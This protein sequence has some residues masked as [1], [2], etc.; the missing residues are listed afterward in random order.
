[1]S[2]ILQDI[3]VRLGGREVVSGLTLPPLPRG[4]F[5][6]IAGPNAAGK[7]TVL[8]A[9]AGL[10]PVQGVMNFEGRDLR[11]MSTGER[12]GLIGFMP[13][14]IPARSGLT[15]FESM[16]AALNAAGGAV[17]RASDRVMGL[18]DR[19]GLTDLA[20]RPLATLS[21]GQR[22]A[23]G[24]AQAMARD[25]Q[26]LLLDEPTSAL[27]PGRQFDILSQAQEIAQEGRVVVAVLHDLALA[28]QWADRIDLLAEGRLIASGAPSAVLTPPL[29]AQVYGVRARVER[30]SAGRA[31]VLV[32]GRI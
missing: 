4:T 19:F 24:L 30:C 23:V 26:M 32:D 25:P 14:N 16:L 5:A 15:V 27:D 22:Q 3:T 8:R 9:V 20:M 1:M 11:G 7:S 10:L 29:L 17:V 18:L 6:V 28:A 13:Q 12:A 2:L 21:G 31:L